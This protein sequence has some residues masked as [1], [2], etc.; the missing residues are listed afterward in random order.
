[1]KMNICLG[2]ALASVLLSAAGPVLANGLNED[3][4]WNFRSANPSAVAANQNGVLLMQEHKAG[5]LNSPVL[6]SSG[7]LGS[8]GLLGASTS[9]TNNENI[10]E[11]VT[12]NTVT[13]TGGCSVSA[14]GGP[15]NA[16]VG[17]STTSSSATA[18]SSI[19]G[20][21]LTNAPTGTQ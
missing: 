4:S 3:G 21:N 15:F 8:G 2:A 19:T 7:G 6:G 17:Q 10:I 13:C 11:N 20:N 16:T 14:T 12:N 9:S 18:R 1:M 5:L